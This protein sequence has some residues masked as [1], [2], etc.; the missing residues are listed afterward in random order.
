MVDKGDVYKFLVGLKMVPDIGE[1]LD[2][3]RSLIENLE[4]AGY[5]TSP[6]DKLTIGLLEEKGEDILDFAGYGGPKHPAVVYNINKAAET[7]AVMLYRWLEKNGISVTHI[8][9]F[10]GEESIDGFRDDVARDGINIFVDD[11][12]FPDRIERYKKFSEERGNLMYSAGYVAPLPKPYFERFFN[13]R[14]PDK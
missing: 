5:E 9:L 4:A 13:S 14:G 2:S 3:G 6:T 1:L 11:Y 7:Y 10:P 8:H 12:A